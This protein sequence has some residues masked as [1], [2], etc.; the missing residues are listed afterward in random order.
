[1]TT[2]SQ[3]DT[4]DEEEL[5]SYEIGVKNTF[6]NNRLVVNASIYLMDIADMQVS[7]KVS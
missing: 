5:W 3:Y 6:F 4:F 1:M 7:E 2:D